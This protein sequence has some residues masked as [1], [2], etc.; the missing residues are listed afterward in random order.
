[1]CVVCVCVRVCIF[2]FMLSS[3]F[4]CCFSP[5]P[6]ELVSG[7]S[8]LRLC[9]HRCARD[10]DVNHHPPPF[11]GGRITVIHAFFSFPSFVC[12]FTDFLPLP[13]TFIRSSLADAAC[14]PCLCLRE[15]YRYSD[16]AHPLPFLPAFSVY[17][18]S[19]FFCFVVLAPHV[20]GCRL[21]RCCVL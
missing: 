18:C 16:V 9:V 6:C 21:C 2:F 14:L 1:M 17:R 12:S 10:V 7:A 13:S 20:C 3:P 8:Q 5:L 4:L 19:F 11:S 15:V